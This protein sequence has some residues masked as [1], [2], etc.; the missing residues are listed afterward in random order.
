MPHLPFAPWLL[1][2]GVVLG[3]I[4][5]VLWWMLPF[6]S[7]LPPFLFSSLLAIG[8]GGCEMWRQ[9]AGK[10]RAPERP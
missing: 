10:K 7:A 4:G 1:L 3:G 5:L 9:R 6:S 2:G 8:Y